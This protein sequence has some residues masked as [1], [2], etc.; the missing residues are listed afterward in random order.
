MPF[1][2]FDLEVF[3]LIWW[4]S[5][6]RLYFQLTHSWHKYMTKTDLFSIYPCLQHWYSDGCRS[7]CVW[8][9]LFCSASQLMLKYFLQSVKLTVAGEAH[10]D[11]WSLHGCQGTTIYIYK[12][13][14]HIIKHDK[15]LCV[16]GNYFNSLSTSPYLKLG[17]KHCPLLMKR[18]DCIYYEDNSLDSPAKTNSDI[19]KLTHHGC[20]WAN[21][22][23]G[24]AGC[25]PGTD[26]AKTFCPSD[27]LKSEPRLSLNIN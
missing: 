3:V 27:I 11:R 19:A 13:K 4:N 12:K 21:C 26:V 22:Y 25:C 23:F 20:G 16:C 24:P 10:V 2:V 15:R 7:R 1:S 18:H 6:F 8:L 9:F 17:W 5:Y 14:K